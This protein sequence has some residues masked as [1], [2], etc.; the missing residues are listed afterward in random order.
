MLAA[1][2]CSVRF[3][4]PPLG[5]PDADTLLSHPVLVRSRQRDPAMPV[6]FT[7]G[8]TLGARLSP[9]CAKQADRVLHADLQVPKS[10]WKPQYICTLSG[11]QRDAHDANAWPVHEPL[12]CKPANS[13][14][15]AG[16]PVLR[17]RDDG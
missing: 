17:H 5:P 1:A 14:A 9:E 13:A 3:F 6:R 7:V 12:K 15:D 2:A 16:K 10:Q 8:M 11:P 4:A